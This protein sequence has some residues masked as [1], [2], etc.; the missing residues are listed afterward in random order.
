MNCRFRETIKV[1]DTKQ[2]IYIKVKR[3]IKESNRTLRFVYFNT[4]Q[5]SSCKI[6]CVRE[7]DIARGV[8]RVK[9]IEDSLMLMKC[10]AS[11]EASLFEI[12]V[13]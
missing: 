3:K 13:M 1:L 6:L 10:I 8:S 4:H 5:L 7:C 11:A 12:V 9:K 2:S